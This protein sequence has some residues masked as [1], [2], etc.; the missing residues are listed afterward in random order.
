[1]SSTP[2]A[3]ILARP[4][5][6]PPCPYPTPTLVIGARTVNYASKGKEQRAVTLRVVDGYVCEQ[7]GQLKKRRT[8][9]ANA[10]PSGR[11]VTVEDKRSEE[12]T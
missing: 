4:R 5:F 1:M 6:A 12:R 3:I 10:E 7:I 2:S 11:P 8:R 9:V